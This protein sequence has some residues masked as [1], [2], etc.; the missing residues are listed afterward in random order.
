MIGILEAYYSSPIGG[1][2][3]G[4]WRTHKILKCGYYWPTVYHDAHDYAGEYN[5]SLRQGAI[6]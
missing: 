4:I 5:Q 2:H 3:S 1:H 6:T